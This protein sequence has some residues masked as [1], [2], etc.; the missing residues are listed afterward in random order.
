MCQVGEP[1]SR[2]GPRNSI[3][4]STTLTLAAALPVP[5]RTKDPS[6]CHGVSAMINHSLASFPQTVQAAGQSKIDL[7]Q[8]C[9]FGYCLTPAARNTETGRKMQQEVKNPTTSNR[10]P[11]VPRVSLPRPPATICG[12]IRRLEARTGAKRSRERRCR[13]RKQEHAADRP[14]DGFLTHARAFFR[15]ASAASGQPWTCCR[16]QRS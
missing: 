9:L 15:I 11:I 13:G 12:L 6:C 1:F 14:T 8:G 4:I 3:Q 16:R 10:D 2:P 7:W 5:W